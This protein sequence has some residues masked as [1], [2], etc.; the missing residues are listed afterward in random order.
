MKNVF[1]PLCCA[2][3]PKTIGF[4]SLVVFSSIGLATLYWGAFV[5]EGDNLVVGHLLQQGYT[6]YSDVFSHHFPFPYYWVAMVVGLFGKSIFGVRLSV[7]VFQFAAFAIVMKLCRTYLLVGTIAL[8]WG[9]VRL[10][11]HG[12]MVVYSSFAG[13]SLLV[14]LLI[15]LLLLQQSVSPDWKHWLTIGFFS[16]V[17]FLSDPLTAYAILITLVFL[18][19]KRPVWGIKSGLSIIGGLSLYALTLLITDSFQAF[20]QDAVLFNAHIY[21]KYNDT[22]PLRFH[23]LYSMAARGLQITSSDWLNFD[24]LRPIVGEYRNLDQWFLTGFL[25]R[26]AIM[27]FVA[28]LALKKKFSAAVFLYLFSAAVLVISRWDFR[29]QPFVMVAL[30]AISAIVT[31]EWRWRLSNQYLSLAQKAIRVVVA[32]MTLWLILRLGA[33]ICLNQQKLSYDVN[34]ANFEKGA[35]RLQELVCHQPDVR[36]AHYP[37]GCYWYWF[38]DLRPVS[39]YVFMWPWV[40][41]VGLSDVIDEL[42]R[43]EFVIVVLQ[44]GKIWDRYYMRQYLR[45]LYKFVKTNYQEVAEGIYISP[46]LLAR[47]RKNGL[48]IN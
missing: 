16:T 17:S 26:F 22:N 29:S 45:P 11:Y 2:I 3:N 7:L 43:R 35:A 47:C 27:V 15:T 37:A 8:M 40:A 33:H 44:D 25:Y 13:T 4:I 6:L 28:F 42:D 46:A 38:T 23:E 5:D 20:W 30:A 1:T 39:K 12:H 31:D 48:M 41:E 32:A 36:L 21:A 10:F 19:L 9:V 14:V 24:P 34:F 18:F